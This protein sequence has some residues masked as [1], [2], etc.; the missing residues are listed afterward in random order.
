M[1]KLIYILWIIMCSLLCWG[2]TFYGAEMENKIKIG[3]PVKSSENIIEVPLTINVV[4]DVSSVNFKLNYQTEVMCPA[5]IEYD[6]SSW[7]LQSNIYDESIKK[8]NMEYITICLDKYVSS[9]NGEIKI[10]VLFTQLT[11]VNANVEISELDCCDK[12]QNEINMTLIKETQVKANEVIIGQPIKIADNTFKTTV[13]INAHIKVQSIN[14]NVYLNQSDLIVKKIEYS[15]TNWMLQSNV[16]DENIDKSSLEYVTIGLDKV[17]VMNSEEIIFDIIF[18]SYEIDGETIEISDL[19]CCDDEQNNVEFEIT[20]DEATEVTFVLGDANEDG[21]INIKDSALV[22][23]Y[24]AGWNV[25]INMNASDVNGDGKINIKDSAL[26][27]R[28]VAGWNV[29]FD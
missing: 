10:K 11:N 16:F 8:T 9:D 7:L 17:D 1:K 23:R 13:R 28:Y 22:R 3:Q 20:I 21:K 5:K 19:D 18:T 26:I 2:E 15:N 25:V 12:N 24:V 27:R 4:S 14:F 6:N 29:T